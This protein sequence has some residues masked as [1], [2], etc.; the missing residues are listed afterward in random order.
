MCPI[1]VDERD[2]VQ[3]LQNLVVRQWFGDRKPFFHGV[4][5]GRQDADH[6]GNKE[7]ACKHGGEFK[8][9]RLCGRLSERK[10]R[11]GRA[12]GLNVDFFDE[13]CVFLDVLEPAF[14][15]SSHQ[16][17][18]KTRRLLS[19]FVAFRIRLLRD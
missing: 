3:I 11:T 9:S 13:L 18:D 8:L 4:R 6:E 7:A 10:G 14:G 15:F 16:S 19:L 1:F 12:D 5:R 17:L 2:T